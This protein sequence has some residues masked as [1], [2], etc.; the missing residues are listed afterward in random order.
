MTQME[1]SVTRD[2]TARFCGSR[3]ST[4]RMNPIQNHCSS[5]FGGFIRY[6]GNLFP[7]KISERQQQSHLSA[8]T[9][10]EALIDKSK[11]TKA[12]VKSGG[13]CSTALKGSASQPASQHRSTRTGHRYCKLT[14]RA[15]ILSREIPVFCLSVAADQIRL[16]S[17]VAAV[18]TQKQ[19]K[20]SN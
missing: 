13:R 6:P 11:A 17:A 3:T 20:A 16:C 7:I 15:P 14:R 4:G 5:Y 8:Q 19:D 18:L 1:E 9:T 2:I 12:K 10:Q